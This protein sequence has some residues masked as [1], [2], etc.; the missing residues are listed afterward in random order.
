MIVAIDGPAGSGKSTVARGLAERLGF[1]YLD[2]GAM[3]RAL[4]LLALEDGVELDDEA[5]LAA[6]ARDNP[7]R[8][9]GDRV[10]VRGKD[11]TD[12]IRSPRVDRV[13]STVAR[14][15]EVRAIMRDRQRELADSGDAVVEGRDIGTVVCPDAEVKVYLVADP[16][17]RARRRLSDRPEIG[18]EALATDLRL[19]DERDA[20]QMQPAGDAEMIDTTE[21]TVE[22]VARPHRAARPGEGGRMNGVDLV[23]WTVGKGILATA[24]RV[25]VRI[26]SYGTERLPREGGCVLAVNHAAFIDIPVLGTV[27]PRRIAFVAKTELFDHPGFAQLIRAHGTIAVRRGES[28]RDALAPHARHRPRRGRARALRRGHAAALRR[29]RRGEARRGHGRDPGGSPGRADCH[30]RLRGLEARPPEP[31]V[32]GLGGTDAVR[33]PSARL[34]GLPGRDQGDRGGDPPAVGVARADARARAPRDA[35]PPRREQI[36]ARPA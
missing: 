32:P 4:T 20:A 21:L 31:G 28:D 33:R 2:T 8:F 13:V 27:C 3:Y 9:D 26:R 35:T 34:E 10:W 23:Y 36:P 22:G 24:T 14:H 6:L 11:V 17:E 7:V 16:T 19:R 15:P 12:A 5:A 30:L 29:A 25:L 18:A 1:R